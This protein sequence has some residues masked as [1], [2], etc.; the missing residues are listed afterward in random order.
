MNQIP[1]PD[2]DIFCTVIDNYG[3]IATCW[4]LA[5]QLN[6]RHGIRVRLWVD[7]LTALKHLYPETNEHLAE[8]QLSQIDVRLWSTPFPN[9]TP[10]PMVIEAFACELPANY[11]Q[12]MLKKASLC[13]N[14]DYFSCE[15][16]VLGCHGLR[17]FQS[18]GLHKY[19]FFP[20]IVS[21][22]GGVLYE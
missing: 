9:I 6:Q 8:Q 16:W 22:T 1:H 11:R 4:R 2:F 21:G 15:D 19:F 20:G 17:S 18:D 7:D 12:A 5:L 13:I 10:A 14:L 3:D